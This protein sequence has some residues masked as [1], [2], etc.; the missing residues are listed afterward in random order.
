MVFGISTSYI[1]NQ[2]EEDDEFQNIEADEYRDLRNRID[3]DKVK[4]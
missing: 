2:Y 4:T 3:K 1:R